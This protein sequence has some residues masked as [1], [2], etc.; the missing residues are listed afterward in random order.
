MTDGV[1]RPDRFLKFGGAALMLTVGLR[2]RVLRAT[3]CGQLDSSIAAQVIAA[4]DPI[5]R[6]DLRDPAFSPASPA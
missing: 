1:P 6:F 2:G 3:G 4:A 5:G